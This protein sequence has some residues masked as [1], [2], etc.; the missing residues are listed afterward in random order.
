M[1]PLQEDR[2]NVYAQAHGNADVHAV[3]NQ[4]SI[5]VV[6]WATNSLAWVKRMRMSRPCL[7]CTGPLFN[8]YEENS[9]WN[10]L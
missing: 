4:N 9:T 10:A 6:A 3:S 2:N 8:L 1:L 5:I 7:G